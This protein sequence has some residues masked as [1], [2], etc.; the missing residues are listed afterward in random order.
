MNKKDKSIAYKYLILVTFFLI[1][2]NTFANPSLDSL[3]TNQ[4]KNFIKV[5]PKTYKQIDSAFSFIRNDTLRIR[6]LLN[7]SQKANYLE[8]ESYALNKIGIIYRNNS[9]YKESLLLHKQALDQAEKADNLELQ[10]I[11]LNMLGV[12]NRRLDLIRNAL[13][14]HTQ[15]LDLAETASAQTD[16][17]KK[18]IAVSRNSLGNIYLALKQYD[19]A[20]DQFNHSLIIEEELNNY[21]GLAI[22]Y[23]NIGYVLEHKGLL[24]EALVSYNTSLEYNNKINSDI[25]RVICNNSKGV[26]YIKQKNYKEAHKVLHSA[27]KTALKLNDNYHLAPVYIN[28][29][30]LQFKEKHYDKSEANLKKGL[31]ISKD[32]KL[33]SSESDAYKYL[34][35]LY[36][37]KDDHKKAIEYYKE[38]VS[39]DQTL[40]NERNLQYVNDL[41]IKYESEK[42]TNRIKELANENEIVK[43]RLE[44]NR[45][46]LLL[47]I[48]GAFLIFGIIYI[49]N[50]QRRLKS[51]KQIITLEQD[52]L[53]NQMNPHFIFNTLNSIKLYIINNEKENA[54]YY[55]NKFS[56][57]I[58]KI[59]VASTEKTI[60]LEEE[61]DTMKLYLNIENIRFDNEINY[62]FK[63]EEGLK[64]E[65][66]QVPSLILQPFLENALWH[67]LSSK[68]ENKKIRIEVFQPKHNAITITI[69]DNGIGRVASRKIKKQKTLKR[70]SVGISLTKERLANYSNRFSNNY[71]LEIEDLY[72]RNSQAAGTKVTI[73][74][75]IESSKSKSA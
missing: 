10:I 61:I 55:L 57:L 24:N 63:I 53:R 60:S 7:K 39:I 70:K 30:W 44:K 19:L 50:R 31:E 35:E 68:A 32:Y 18:S 17:L 12:V 16:V 41:I 64:T 58:R 67:G 1:A 29:G 54:V 15:A 49:L 46:I 40:I 59:L 45:R 5:K 65:A 3:F 75:P 26:V 62:H 66:I 20:L 38:H 43:L 2:N 51:E 47:S 22:N 69:T 37:L 56:K 11:S 6:Y 34:S 25:G 36:E 14:Y 52:M 8:G 73:E 33:I 48:A 4:V 9:K 74:I 71:Y 72:D 21:L 42:K 13:D 27:L 23:H 28:L